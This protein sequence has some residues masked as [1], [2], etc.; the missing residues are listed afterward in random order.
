MME[1]QTMIGI[2][3]TKRMI[4]TTGFLAGLALAGATA[5]AQ[6]STPTAPN[7]GGAM[8]GDHK[9]GGMM[10]GMM[11]DGMRQTMTRMMGACTQAMESMTPDKGALSGQKG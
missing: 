4:A 9:P 8:M 6:T 10:S 2:N 5:F 11:T 7:Q 1:L 3:T